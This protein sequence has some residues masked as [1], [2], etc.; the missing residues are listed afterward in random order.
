MKKRH[1]LMLLVAAFVC[2]SFV[3]GCGSGATS[4]GGGGGSYLL[5]N[6]YV[7]AASTAV[8]EEGS[9]LY[10]FHAITSAVT[11]ADVDSA[12]IH[13]SKG[14]YVGRVTVKK[15]VSIYGG[16]DASVT[17]EPTSRSAS[18]KVIILC[19][20]LEA[21][22]GKVIAVAALNITSRTTLEYLTVITSSAATAGGDS[23]GIYAYNSGGLVIMSCEV[24][25]GM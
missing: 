9:Q 11:S 5:G 8:T 15:G 21:V 7:D 14:T 20:T 17:W 2:V 4:G 1:V 24:H 6:L 25:A 10:P 16:Y 23:I 22:S 12:T 3:N 19:T 18:N 13:V